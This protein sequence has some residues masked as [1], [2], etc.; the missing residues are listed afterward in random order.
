MIFFVL[1]AP[2]NVPAGDDVNMLS[3]P[4]K[5]IAPNPPED[6]GSDQT[7]QE[8]PC[9]LPDDGTDL[10]AVA[11]ISLSKTPIMRMKS[12]SEPKRIAVSLKAADEAAEGFGGGNEGDVGGDQEPIEAPLGPMTPVEM[13]LHDSMK[14]GGA[15]LLVGA[16]SEQ[17]RKSSVL[18]TPVLPP[19]LAQVRVPVQSANVDLFQLYIICEKAKL[20]WQIEPSETLH[21]IAV[22][23]VHEMEV[24]TLKM[25]SL[26]FC[27]SRSS[28]PIRFVTVC[29]AS[30][31][32]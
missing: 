15:G 4:A 2:D 9:D 21:Q 19:G 22:E 25:I 3:P 10:A 7:A 16:P 30:H 18:N 26:G 13:L 32:A 8:Q 12:K 24:R 17:L 31:E 1:I 23:C 27:L 28:W 14:L 20:A 11:A 5:R 6:P 29:L